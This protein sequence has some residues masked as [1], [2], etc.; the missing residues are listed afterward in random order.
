MDSGQSQAGDSS[1]FIDD[2]DAD[3]VIHDGLDEE[4]EED[5]ETIKWCKIWKRALHRMQGFLN[6]FS[7]SKMALENRTGCELDAELDEEL[8]GERE[9]LKMALENRT[10][11]IDL[12]VAQTLSGSDMP[13]R[14]K[15]IEH[16]AD[17]FSELVRRFSEFRERLKT[18][19]QKKV[20][21]IET[22]RELD[23]HRGGGE[24]SRSP[25]V[26]SVRPE[27][28]T[29]FDV[30]MAERNARTIRAMWQQDTE[31]HDKNLGEETEILVVS[32]VDV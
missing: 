14:R 23:N 30:A 27:T 32:E 16:Q 25:R 20:A 31:L 26:H 3:F 4:Q 21:G 22:K 28:P 10:G 29:E 5:A 19:Y 17:E 8:D 2:T 24:R 15:W 13:I 11:K 18:Y 12:G 1:K 6:R 7:E 9:A